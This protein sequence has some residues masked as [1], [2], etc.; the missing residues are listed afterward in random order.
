MRS[1][2]TMRRI[3]GEVAARHRLTLD[4]LTGPRVARPLVRARWE[5]MAAIRAQTRFSLPQIGQFFN[6]D[7]TTVLAGIRKHLGETT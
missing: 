3:A 6:R 4:D 5:A 1:S 7:H 2:P